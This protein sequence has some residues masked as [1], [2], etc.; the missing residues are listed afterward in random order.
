[1]KRFRLLALVT[2]LTGILSW[3]Q[4]EKTQA[5]YSIN[6]Q[7]FYDQLSPYGYWMPHPSYGYVWMPQAGQN[8]RPYYSEGYWMYT[9]TGWFWNSNYNWGWATFHYGSWTYDN[10]YGWLWI[11]GYDWA[12]AWVAWGSYGGNYGWA[13][14]GPNYGY[15]TN[16]CPP[17]NYWCFVPTRYIGQRH[18]HN[19][20]HYVGNGNSI[21]MGNNVTVNNVTNITILNN[22]YYNNNTNNTYYG[23]RSTPVGP[24]KMEVE[25]ASGARINTVSVR[26]STQPGR[27]NVSQNQVSIYRPTVAKAPT[28]TRPSSV[29]NYQGS[30]SATPGSIGVR[31]ANQQ[32]TLAL[33]AQSRTQQPV[34]GAAPQGRME[35]NYQRPQNTQNLERSNVQETRKPSNSRN[36]GYQAPSTVQRQQPSQAVR[37]EQPRTQPGRSGATKMQTATPTEPTGGRTNNTKVKR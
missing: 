26:E 10:Y 21:Y 14:M 17:V 1:M 6:F 31:E 32:N 24:P 29:V 22:N 37:T 13:P 23:H 36:A 5:Q 7:V 25:R 28:Q 12:P 35:N 11:P 18:W 8:F 3:C 30:R 15:A 9:E 27:S 4:V 16:Y 20:H 34:Q 2:I 19:H 33:P